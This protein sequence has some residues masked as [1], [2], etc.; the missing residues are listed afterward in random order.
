VTR[1]I[2]QSIVVCIDSVADVE[3]TLCEQCGLLAWCEKRRLGGQAGRP[4]HGWAR[5]EME[6]A[7]S[8]R[9]RVGTSIQ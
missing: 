5:D 8:Q 6:I 2:D 9:A 7:R 4:G 1:G 3:Q